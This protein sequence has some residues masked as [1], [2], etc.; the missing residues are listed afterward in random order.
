VYNNVRKAAGKSYWLPR[1]EN[2][3]DFELSIILGIHKVRKVRL[4]YRL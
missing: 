3:F 4:K 1:D 2:F